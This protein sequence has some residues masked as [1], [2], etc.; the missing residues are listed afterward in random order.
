MPVVGVAGTRDTA[1]LARLVA[2]LLATR[3]PPYRP[4]LRATACSSN[5]RRVDARDSA[6]WEAGQ[7][8]LMNR[9][10]Q[11]AV[12]E[13]GAAPSCPKAWPTTGARSAS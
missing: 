10:V 2:W 6:N 11:A 13:N 7:R 3:R 4:G 1:M 12:F 5:G 8:L 9:A